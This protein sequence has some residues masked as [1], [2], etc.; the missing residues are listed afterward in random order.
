MSEMNLIMEGWRGFVLKEEREYAL[1]IHE[2]L[3]H[4]FVKDLKVLEEN[5]AELNEI[6]SKVGDFAKKAFTVY[7]DLKRGAIKGV[8]SKSIDGAL[9]AL[10]FVE[11]KLKEQAPDLISKIKIDLFELEILSVK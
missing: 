10:E 5:K 8:L 4:E 2:N 9:K 11:D 3:I 6:L 1:Q 7:S